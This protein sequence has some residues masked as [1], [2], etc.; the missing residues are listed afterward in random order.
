MQLSNSPVATYNILL[1]DLQ[2]LTYL[3][4]DIRS[5]PI[6]GDASNL[7][8]IWLDMLSCSSSDSSLSAC[9]QDDS[10][11]GYADCLHTSDSS[12]VAVDCGT[13]T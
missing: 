12:I 10:I 13:L 5:S 7:R 4:Y 6:L 8:P 3:H 1:S 11:I 9:I 2:L